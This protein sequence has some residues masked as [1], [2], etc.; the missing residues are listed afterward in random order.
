M[1][2]TTEKSDQ[3]TNAEASP[4]TGIPAYDWSGK[5]RI[6]RFDFTQG[7]S[8][9][10]ANSTA[11]LVRLPT[12]R[13]RVYL[14]QS[15]I[16][17]SAFGSSRT[18]DL[19]HMAYTDEAGD[20][21]AADEDSL[22]AAQSVSGAASYVPIGTVGGEESYLF[23]SHSTEGVTIIAKCEGGTI[24]AAATIKGYFVYAVE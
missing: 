15:R 18:L 8:A 13:V 19:G 11:E 3:I 17:T 2:V 12:G 5:L 10:D 20:T 21:V 14:V 16:T 9:G 24:P 4:R 1:A 6:A 22:D 7:S 23:S